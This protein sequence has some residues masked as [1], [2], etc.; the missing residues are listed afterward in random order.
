MFGS[1]TQSLQKRAQNVMP[2]GVNSNFRYW[3]EGI[4]PYVDK[5]KGGY[6]WDVDGKKYIDYRMAFGPIIL[7]H[8]YPEVDSKVIEEIQRGVLFAMTG[9]LE[10]AVAEMI[11]EMAPAVEMVRMACSGTE[12]TMHAIRV[13]R[14]YTGRDIILKFEGNYHGMHDHALWSTYAPV[15]AYGNRRSPIAVPASSG[16]P[17]AMREFIITLPFNDFEGFERVMRSYGEQIAAVITEPCQG[18]CAAINPQDGFLQL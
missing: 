8:A 13:A 9:E 6:L 4:T 14:A 15:E 3:G 16:I 18:N 17:K 10:V 5:A 12:A 7:G 2:L 11:T 1:K